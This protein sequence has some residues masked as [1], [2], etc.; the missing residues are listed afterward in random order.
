MATP[1]KIVLQKIKAVHGDKFTL[2]ESTYT[3][4][5]NQISAHCNVCGYDWK[6]RPDRLA[7]IEG[8]SGCPGC[9]GKARVTFEQFVGRAV[10]K[11][12][13]VIDF[14]KNTYT[15]VNKTVDAKCKRCEYKWITTPNN[16][17]RPT[18][19]GCPRC[20]GQ[21]K[22]TFEM[23]LEDVKEIHGD[24]FEFDPA[25]YTKVLENVSAK[26]KKCEHEWS[27][28]PHSMLRKD[29]PSGCPKCSGKLRKTF[30][31]FVEDVKEVHGDIFE[32]E[33]ES[34]HST[35]KRVN[36]ACKKCDYKWSPFAQHFL[37]RD[38]PSGCSKCAGNARKTPQEIIEMSRERHGGTY[39]YREESI[40]TTSK[41]MTVVC[42]QHGDFYQTPS[43]HIHGGYG[44]PSCKTKNEAKI[45]KIMETMFEESFPKGRY[46]FLYWETTNKNL[47][48]DGYCEELGIAFEYNG[49]QHYKF[50]EMWHKTEDKLEDQKARDRFREKKCQEEG[51]SLV[52]IPYWLTELD[53]IL[54]TI[55]EALTDEQEEIFSRD[56]YEK[57][58]KCKEIWK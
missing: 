2:D 44:C 3:N 52:V 51:I 20:S 54:D 46:D 43:D 17:L 40:T 34:Y 8:G 22:K 19:N 49:Q 14:D 33:R 13:D 18:S 57:R 27:A 56:F 5:K 50:V 58:E 29:Q 47:E 37:R 25:T 45:K 10:E 53:D 42:K 41:K 6:P 32:F 16:I 4:M 30:E 15:S 21:A 11:F 26:C 38:V 55:G 28:N 36:A 24:I 9:S 31:M 7:K 1:F 39:E 23:F 35:Q 48:L 12:G